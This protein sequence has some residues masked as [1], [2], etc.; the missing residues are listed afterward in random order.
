MHEVPW[1]RVRIMRDV[2]GKTAGG[3]SFL[4]RYGGL[5]SAGLFEFPMILVHHI[6]RSCYTSLKAEKTKS[7]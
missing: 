2:I 6:P 1:V 3:D 4:L 5:A 7:N